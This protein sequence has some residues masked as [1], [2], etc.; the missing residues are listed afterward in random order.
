MNEIKISTHEAKYLIEL[1]SSV[2]GK[3]SMHKTGSS[4]RWEQMYRIADIHNVA[5]IAYY[6]TLGVGGKHTGN[7]KPKFEQRYHSAVHAERIYSQV[8]PA[9]LAQFEIRKIHAMPI[10]D[11][12]MRTYYPQREMSGMHGVRILVESGKESAVH[13]IMRRMDFEQKTTNDWGDKIYYK[14]PGATVTIQTGLHFSNKRIDKYYQKEIKSYA[15]MGDYYHIHEM[16]A[17]ELYTYIVAS[18]AD[19][20]TRD[21]YTIRDVV[22]FYCFRSKVGE[23]LNE[24]KVAEYMKFMELEKFR[25][26]LCKLSD[27]WFTDFVPGKTD[28]IFYAFEKYVITCGAD[29]REGCVGILPPMREITKLYEKELRKKRRRERINWLFP[30]HYYMVGMFKVLEDVPQLLPFLW[31]VRLMRMWIRSV[32]IRLVRLFSPIKSRIIKL[33]K[34]PDE[35]DFVDEE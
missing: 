30:Q 20:C 21:E 14:I 5:N 29:G 12:A 10:R 13:D 3:R 18:A 35:S 34:G 23:K 26:M 19:S 32:R 1:I 11:Y 9:L 2:L 8:L 25:T 15:R 16:N 27:A 28:D 17:E 31:I 4:P 33:I 24:A 7:W 6:A 22:D